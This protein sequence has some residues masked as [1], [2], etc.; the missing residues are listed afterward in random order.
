[1]I[2]TRYLLRISLL[3]VG[4]FASHAL[5]S[6]I[7]ADQECVSAVFS[8]VGGLSFVGVGYGKYYVANCQ[9]PLKVASIY[10]VSKTYCP[11]SDLDPGIEYVK[12]LC[13]KYGGAEPLSEADVAANLTDEAISQY[14]ILDQTDDLVS[15]NLTTPVLISKHWFDLGFKTEVSFLG[16]ISRCVTPL[17]RF[18]RSSGMLRLEIAKTMGEI[19][20]SVL[21]EESK[22][23]T[24]ITLQMG[25]VRILGHRSPLRNFSSP[26]L[27]LPRRPCASVVDR[28]RRYRIG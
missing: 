23:L 6:T 12:S 16:L 17:L 2:A 28:P 10:A 9:N 27:P 11:P 8:I 25:H 26:H 13:R 5:S 4:L 7:N 22:E 1:M 3:L 24:C 15:T 14:P 19:T 21:L 18:S 20:P